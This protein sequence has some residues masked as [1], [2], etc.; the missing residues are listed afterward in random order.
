MMEVNRHGFAEEGHWTVAYSPVP[1]GTAPRGIGG[2]LATVH[3]ITEKVIAERRVAAMRD[4]GTKATE[5]KTAEDVCTISAEILAMYAK[6]IPFALLYLIDSERK[7]A[8]LTATAGVRA[9]LRMSPPIID[10]AAQ[11]DDPQPWP[12]I[13]VMHTE[14]MKVVD[15]LTDEFGTEA[16]AGTWFD[17]PRQAVVVPIRSN[18]VHQLAGFLVAGVSIRL[19][20]DEPYRNFYQFV[21]GQI[22]TAIANA[23]AY[24][25][26]RKRADAL[27][28]LDR[29]KTAFFSNVSHELRT[30]LTLMLGPLEELKAQFGC[31]MSS[32][33]ASQYRQVDVVHRNGLRLLKLVNQLLDF[34]RIE[35]GRAQALYEETDLA[36]FTADLASV[37][38]S[39]IEKAGLSLIVDCPPL[40]EP[41][42][43]DRDMWEKIVLNLLSNAFKFTFSGE[44]EVSLGTADSGLRTE[45]SEAMA[46]DPNTQHSA[47]TRSVTLCVRDTGIGIQEDQLGKIFERFHRVPGSQGRPY[48]GTGIGLSLVQELARLHGGSVSVESRYGKGSTFRVFIPLGKSHLP[49][50]HIGVAHDKTSTAVTALSFVEEAARWLPS[51]GSSECA[52]LSAELRS[53]QPLSPNHSGLSTHDSA[54]SKT[55]PRIL[56]ADDNADM[57]EYAHRLL[58]AQGYEVES[59][60]DGQAALDCVQANPPDIVLTDVMMPRLDGFG[61]LQALRADERTRTLPIIMLSARA[62]EEARVAGL[63]AGTDDYL[64]K[65]FSARE[66]LARVRSQL[67]LARLRRENEERVSGILSSI[68]DGFQT[69]GADYRFKYF[70]EAARRTYIEQGMNPDE[71][72]G[73][74]I[75]DEVFPAERDK[76]WAV[77]LCR[78]MSK[79]I[80]TQAE[81]FH[82]PWQRWFAARF[83]PAPDG[84]ISVFFQDITER[85]QAEKALRESEERQAFLLALSDALRPLTAPAD[86][87]GLAAER[88]GERF[89]LNRVFYAEIAG[90]RMTVERD[91]ARNV[92]SIVGEHNLEDFDTAMLAAYRDG[93]VITVNDVGAEPRLNE[94]ARVG[95]RLR[96][97]G[98]YVDV[99]LF[100]EEQKVGLLA[101]QSATSRD[102]TAAEQNLFHEVGE[103]VK[104]AVE[105]ARAEEALRQSERETKRARLRRGH[106]AYLTHS[107]A[108]VG[109]RFARE[110]RQC[111]VL[112]NFPGQFRRDR[113][114]SC[115]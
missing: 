64:V 104:S 83:D 61:L 93:A 9:H 31:S 91:Y 16:P 33:G 80:P 114:T 14:E 32:L 12:L 82:E 41:V 53:E 35:A 40:P 113:R 39:A 11:T 23:R 109:K 71:Q 2:V 106:V 103:R 27:A 59:V 111:G 26:E 79:R 89:G 95:L 73:R 50:K 97:V 68:T 78:T 6:D 51:E 107:V 56:L 15:N 30:P 77:S 63:R 58:S 43:V 38:R 52:V 25:E 24:E 13:E 115:V 96:Q 72:I 17:P 108:R 1:D 10:L 85:K 37:F 87:A 55:R 88:L 47:L 69:I 48:E 57:R 54:L 102:W 66:L 99:V 36:A 34:S 21:A 42:F 112:S 62:G 84:G 44:I 81:I 7:L 8:R 74:H 60:A 101:L 110:H 65:P 45:T 86:I 28:E 49:H 29:T 22:A 4:L 18:T 92:G 100:E 5:A 90:S 20:L 19:Q 94:E 105:R 67:E 98:A 76:P 75:F 46:L 70:N 3:E